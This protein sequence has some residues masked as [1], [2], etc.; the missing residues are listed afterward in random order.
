MNISPSGLAGPPHSDRQQQA[1]SE[2]TEQR[3]IA[4]ARA[5]VVAG[6]RKTRSIPRFSRTGDNER[7]VP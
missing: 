3:W 7:R 2:I 6:Q 5:L 4:L 1:I